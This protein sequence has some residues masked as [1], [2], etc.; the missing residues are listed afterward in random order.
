MLEPGVDFRVAELQRFCEDE[1][2]QN[3]STAGAA[4]WS[5]TLGWQRL[6]LGLVSVSTERF[7]FLFSI[8][9][10]NLGLESPFWVSW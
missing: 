4:G 7:G 1:M 10:T 6:A 3:F 2:G 5:H 8:N 9:N